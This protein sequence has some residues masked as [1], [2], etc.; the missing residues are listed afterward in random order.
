MEKVTVGDETGD[1]GG[2]GGSDANVEV[3]ATTVV[4][5]AEGCKLLSPAT[6]N[7]SGKFF[8]PENAASRSSGINEDG[9]T[10]EALS[11][12]VETCQEGLTDAE[13]E[14][15]RLKICAS[16]FFENECELD[17]VLVA[18]QK[19]PGFYL[20]T[21]N[22][23]TS[24]SRKYAMAIETQRSCLRALKV[25]QEE[26]QDVNLTTFELKVEIKASLKEQE[27][28]YEKKLE[29]L[30][31]TL[32]AVTARLE[33]L[34]QV[35]GQ[36]ANEEGLN[37]AAGAGDAAT[38]TYLVSKGLVPSVKTTDTFVHYSALH[39]AC[40]RAKNVEVVK[41]L[42]PV[43][44]AL[45]NTKAEYSRSSGEHSGQ[46]PLQLAANA[47]CLPVVE[48]LMEHGAKIRGQNSEFR[49]P[50]GKDGDAVAEFLHARNTT[51][52]TIFDLTGG[53]V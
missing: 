16:D 20:N 45:I 22:K 8:S 12:K 46:T 17:K 13:T 4:D 6:V 44:M 9:A 18:V 5:D 28:V 41:I 14:L 36:V 39:L 48:L 43:S 3:I 24:F 49:I 1:C 52:R 23:T 25:A 42:L 10:T 27:A 53:R 19:D 26:A 29:K 50:T 11:A 51:G 31:S 33:L 15:E 37:K 35:L 40:S 38:V 32:S 47:V 34:D 2:G 30:E 7:S 21:S